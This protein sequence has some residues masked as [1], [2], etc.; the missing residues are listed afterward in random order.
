LTFD[1]KHVV[2]P[3]S[4]Q[5][6]PKVDLRELKISPVSLA[7]ALAI[8]R[9]FGCMAMNGMHKISHPVSDGNQFS[10][11]AWLPTCTISSSFS[12]SAL[13]RFLTIAPGALLRAG[14]LV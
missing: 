6:A 5:I 11:N 13:I 12:T 10:E 7:L 1:K 9:V 3:S 8:L 14:R 2:A 4:H